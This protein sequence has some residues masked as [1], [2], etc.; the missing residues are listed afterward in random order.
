MRLALPKGLSSTVAPVRKSPMHAACYENVRHGGAP[1]DGLHGRYPV[2]VPQAYI[3]DHQVGGMPQG[4]GNGLR[5]RGGSAANSV[6]NSGQKFG[7][8]RA[9][10]GVILDQQDAQPRHVS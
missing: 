4:G 6:P 2:A 3:D 8:E 5:L 7:K 9:D 10:H 1:E